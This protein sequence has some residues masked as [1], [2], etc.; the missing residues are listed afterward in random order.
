MDGF[1]LDAINFAVHDRA[2]R[3]NPAA[4]EDGRRRTRPSD[5][6]LPTYTRNQPEVPGFLEKLRA[7]GGSTSKAA[8]ILGISPRKIQYK[9]HE[10]GRPA[11]PNDDEQS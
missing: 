10:Y 11:Q 3:D 5:F 6:Q 8:K 7:V 4:P 1:R 9:L 2:L